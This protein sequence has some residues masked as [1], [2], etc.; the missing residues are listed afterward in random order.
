MK[1]KNFAQ[2]LFL[3]LFLLAISILFFY[4]T[5]KQI[6]TGD[7]PTH[8]KLSKDLA[9][10]GFI[11]GFSHT[12]FAKLVILFR[13]IFPFGFFST[14][15]QFLQEFI[16]EHS[17]DI[18]AI[19]VVTMAHIAS[20]IIIWMK[21]RK[22]LLENNIKHSEILSCFIT[23]IVIIVGPI[24]VFTLPEN[25]YLGYFAPNIYHNPTSILLK[26]LALIWFFLI[27][28]YLFS[29]T[30][31]KIFVYTVI[32]V[33]LAAVAKPNFSLTIL[34]ALVIVYFVFYLRY[35]KSIN[36][37]L[38]VGGMFI[39]SIAV[40]T[41]QYWIAYASDGSNKIIFSPFSSLLSYSP[42]IFL[43]I[44]KIFMSVPFP[45]YITIYYWKVVSKEFQFRLGWT[46]FIIGSLISVL[47]MEES[48]FWHGNFIWGPM[49]GSFIL[50][51]ITGIYYFSDFFG[52]VQR[53]E[54]VWNDLFPTVL[55]LVHFFCGLIYFS[56]SLQGKLIFSG[57]EILIH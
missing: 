10:F 4:V 48:H 47:F 50:F 51:V 53:K 12:L 41:A 31:I 38:V 30:D 1:F 54:L 22:K 42:N 9:E 21:A 55:L 25:I 8:I 3:L 40:L 7:Y 32:I 52:K 35:T 19:I 6:N 33:F 20:A 46:N 57:Q 27:T 56:L 45:L 11:R 44:L 36:W 37:P 39:V 16:Y 24:F 28:D 26:P 34:P 29:K 23:L 2:K 17:Y 14:T 5:Y 13:T 49:I 15:S 18:S 43:V